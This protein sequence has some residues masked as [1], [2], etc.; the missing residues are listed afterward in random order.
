MLLAFDVH[1]RENEARIVGVFFNWEDIE[2]I[3][4]VIENVNEVKEYIPGEFYKRE[5]PCLIKVIAKVDLSNIEAIIIDSPIY[6]DNF[7]TFGLGGKL[8]ESLNKK[9][10]IIGLAKNSFY[11]NSMTVKEVLMGMSKKP[12]YVSTIGIDLNLAVEKVKK[13]YGNYLIPDILKKLDSITKHHSIS[14]VFVFCV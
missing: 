1:Y 4:I 12:L 10:P 3:R 13:M 9:I 5:L 6:V 11:S 7:E 2:P 14:G 8:Y